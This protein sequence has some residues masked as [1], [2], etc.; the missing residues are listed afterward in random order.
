MIVIAALLLSVVAQNGTDCRHGLFIG[1]NF[2]VLEDLPIHV[3]E[4]Y[5]TNNFSLIPPEF[6]HLLRTLQHHSEAFL[7]TCPAAVVLEHLVD[8]EVRLVLFA[9]SL[10]DGAGTSELIKVQEIWK[11]YNRLRE[12]LADRLSDP[13][14]L[15]V[16]PIQ[17]G[18]KRIVKYFNDLWPDEKEQGTHF[19]AELHTSG[20]LPVSDADW[21]THFEEVVWALRESGATEFW[22]YGGSLIALLRYGQRSGELTNGKVAKAQRKLDD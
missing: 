8:M 17:Q 21:K 18:E 10:E 14:T 13:W 16:W 5:R 6:D 20:R 12:T 3:N 11:E 1:G 22:P 19:Y 7:E 9:R 15:A 2:T 4:F